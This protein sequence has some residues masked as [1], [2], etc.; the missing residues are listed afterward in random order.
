MSLKI[1]MFARVASVYVTNLNVCLGDKMTQKLVIDEDST[2]AELPE[3]KPE[4][5]KPVDQDFKTK[6][7]AW[8]DQASYT[9]LLSRWRFG[10]AGDPIFI[11]DVGR[12]F[13]A[14]MSELKRADPAGAVAASKAIGWGNV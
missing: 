7:I 13:E 11:G 9:E 8:I 1:W 3:I 4:E 14:R 10:A 12:H 5:P 2:I 6:M